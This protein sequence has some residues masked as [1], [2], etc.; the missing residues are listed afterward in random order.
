MASGTSERILIELLHGKGAHA[1]PVACIEDITADLAG[2]KA[3]AIPHSIWQIVWH[4]NYWMDYEL[5]RIRGEAPGY[6][7]HASESWP[8]ESAQPSE[9]G[10]SQA[11]ARF[12]ALLEG[13]GAL[14]RATDDVL[15]RQVSA[16]HAVHSQQSSSV[17]GVLW[18]I[19]A[20]NSYHV[21]QIAMVRRA[22]GSWPPRRGGDSW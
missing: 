12:S 1:D 7:G 6:P 16:T 10:W 3:A 11:V 21:G 18:Q 4:M 13:L 20:H 14:A 2:R 8:P 22:L 9:E 5:K 15:S 17:L 19:I